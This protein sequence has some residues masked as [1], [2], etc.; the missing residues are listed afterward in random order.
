MTTTRCV[1]FVLMQHTFVVVLL[2]S[3]LLVAEPGDTIL[4]L[5]GHA[6]VKPGHHVK[7]IKDTP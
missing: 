6:N 5:K 3:V 7:A 4:K 2:F 1:R